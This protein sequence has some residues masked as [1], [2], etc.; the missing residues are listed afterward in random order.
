[1]STHTWTHEHTQS[2]TLTSH[3][4]HQTH[5]THITPQTQRPHV[6]HSIAQHTTTPPPPF[7]SPHTLTHANI[8]NSLSFPSEWQWPTITRW[9]RAGICPEGQAQCMDPFPVWR[10]KLR[11]KFV[12]VF[13]RRSRATWYEVHL[14]W[15]KMWSTLTMIK[16]GKILMIKREMFL[17]KKGNFDKKAK[18]TICCYFLDTFFW[19]KN[20]F[21]DQNVVLAFW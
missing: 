17:I 15:K 21:F 14:R 16:K 2:L 1:M 8:I 3:L 10:K 5:H 13:L 6:Q 19:T 4:T 7:R 11:N 18:K 9:V 12:W 20:T